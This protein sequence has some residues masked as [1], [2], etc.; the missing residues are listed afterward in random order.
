[1]KGLVPASIL[2]PL[3]SNEEQ[4]EA[5]TIQPC[6]EDESSFKQEDESHN[7]EDSHRYV[8]DS[9]KKE[10]EVDIK[11]ICVALY[12]FE[13]ISESTL[14]I[15][16]GDRFRVLQKHDDNM[17]SDWWLLEKLD[18][19]TNSIGYVPANYVSLSDN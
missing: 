13:S 1:M 5:V 2:R 14:T 6:Q 3:V 11:L 9:N 10:E 16:E 7:L 4:E 15:E 8:N 12:A 17:N 18:T 19:A